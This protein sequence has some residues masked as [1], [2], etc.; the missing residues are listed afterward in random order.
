MPRLWEDYCRFLS[1]QRLVTRTRE[2]FDRALRAL[3]VTQ[4][5]RIW[6]LYLEFVRRV[7]IP[8]LAVRVQRRYL[9]LNVTA[10]HDYVDYLISAGFADEAARQ[11][12]VAIDSGIQLPRR[13]KRAASAADS[14]AADNDAKSIEAKRDAIAGGERRLWLTLIDLCA[15]HAS[16]VRSVRLEPVVRSALDRFKD[17]SARLWIALADY[18]IR[19]GNFDRARDVFE[20]ALATVSSVRDFSQLWDAYSRFEDEL[21]AALM[22]RA[23]AAGTADDASETAAFERR[24][25]RYERLI[26]RQPFLLNAVLLRQNKHNVHEWHKRV[27]LYKAK[28]DMETVLKTYQEALTTVDARQVSCSLGVVVGKV[29]ITS[30]AGRWKI[31]FAVAGVCWTLRRTRRLADGA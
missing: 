25:A 10:I 14:T 20:E 18:S 22:E 12:V 4:H 2:A 3:P 19:L 15:K 1:D 28:G 7:N 21:I 8:A 9:K 31:A 24:L 5:E 17:E 30:V 23:Q 16:Q 27:S 6:K 29:L 13:K 11:L 26:E